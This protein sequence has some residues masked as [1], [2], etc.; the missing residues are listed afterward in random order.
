MKV[1]EGV[2]AHTEIK[3]TGIAGKE[4]NA[5][6]NVLNA[7]DLGNEGA[8][9]FADEGGLDILDSLIASDNIE[10]AQKAVS[11]L[12]KIV[13][14]NKLA[15]EKR[16]TNDK[17]VNNR[18]KDLKVASQIA[19]ALANQ[20]DDDDN[21]DFANECI[22]LLQELTSEAEPEEIG[23]DEDAIRK[24]KKATANRKD[25]INMGSAFIKSL[26]HMSQVAAALASEGHVNEEILLAQWEVVLEDLQMQ[27]I[28]VKELKTEDGKVYYL[29][30]KTGATSW[31]KPLMQLNLPSINRLSSLLTG[32]GRKNIPVVH[33][34]GLLLKAIELQSDNLGDLKIL[35]ETLEK[36]SANKANLAKIAENNGIIIISRTLHKLISRVDT[37][38]QQ[39]NTVVECE[40]SCAILAARFASKEAFKE[41]VKVSNIIQLL[42]HAHSSS[43]NEA[44]SKEAMASYGNFAYDYVE[45]IELMNKQG[46]VKLIEKVLQT[47]PDNVRIMELTLVTLS[48]LMYGNDAIKRNIGLTCGDEVV[49]VIQRHNEHKSLQQAAMRTI[50]N[51]ASIDENIRWLLENECAATVVNCIESHCDDMEVVSIAVDVLANLASVEDE[52]FELQLHKMML[53][54]GTSDCIMK[55][56]QRSKDVQLIES[57]WDVISAITMEEEL[58]HDYLVPAGI[59][60]CMSNAMKK[61]DWHIG[62]MEHVAHL[63]HAMCYYEEIL[64]SIAEE[65]IVPHLL[66]HVATC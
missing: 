43:M 60:Q 63:I 41:K 18:L 44:M 42:M 28:K 24:I 26:A 53:K 13:A 32:I 25:S 45:G 14:Q 37:D 62:I 39:K 16:G 50:G 3:N 11:A 7:I 40:I 52:Q 10:N 22:A 49:D 27:D 64:V 23:L 34:L 33:N 17:R 21:A 31:D 12:S 29:N 54:Q 4:S 61:Y 8:G 56:I 51:L 57:C 55:L 5:V 20:A 36:F 58:C 48:N 38:A 6:V 46:I 9:I 59:V 30:Q 66:C 15:S 19:S 1:L 2:R 65:E 35:V 47:F